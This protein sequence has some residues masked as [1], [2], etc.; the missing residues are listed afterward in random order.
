MQERM[1][2]LQVFYEPEHSTIVSCR[3]LFLSKVL[4]SMFAVLCSAPVDAFAHGCTSHRHCLA[5]LGPCEEMLQ[6]K[7]PVQS[8]QQGLDVP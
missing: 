8:M 3:K 2:T 6:L 5:C 1:V 7:Q 4:T